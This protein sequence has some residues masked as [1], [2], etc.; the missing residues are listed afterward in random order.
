MSRSGFHNSTIPKREKKHMSSFATPSAPSGGIKW[1]T[2]KGALL[3]IDP[4]DYRT[5]IATT[6][7]EADAVE[8]DV[9]VIEGPNAGESYA[10]T[11]VF[12]KLLASQLKNQIGQRVLGRLGQGQAKSGQ[13]AP[14]ILQEA[15]P[16]DIATAEAWVAQQNKPAVT[17]A[18]APF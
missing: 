3:L 7:G 12:P 15:T 17:S 14:W 10:D 2:V 11:L 4:K 18:A 8:A 1:D 5:G 9:H 6:F 16:A 13:S